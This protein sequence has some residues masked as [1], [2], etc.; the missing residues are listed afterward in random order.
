[1][2]LSRAVVLPTRPCARFARRKKALRTVSSLAL[3]EVV[4]VVV[5][6]KV[7]IMVVRL[8]MEEVIPHLTV[9]AVPKRS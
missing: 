6:T 8:V 7:L 1:M 2:H 3:E 9:R 4:V 5:V